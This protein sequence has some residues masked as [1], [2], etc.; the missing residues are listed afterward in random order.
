MKRPKTK[1]RSRNYV[2]FPNLAEWLSIEEQRDKLIDWI[3]D[4][5]HIDGFWMR[6]DRLGLE[7]RIELYSEWLLGRGWNKQRV[8][9]EVDRLHTFIDKFGD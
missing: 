6:D 8:A 7:L 4:V 2:K 5:L 3:D 1:F 9:E